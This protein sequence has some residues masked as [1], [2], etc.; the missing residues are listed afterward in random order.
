MN[1]I[2]SVVLYMYSTMAVLAEYLDA[3]EENDYETEAHL[4]DDKV[5]A[6]HRKNEAGHQNRH[7]AEEH[8]KA[9]I[10]PEVSAVAERVQQAGQ[11]EVS[12]H[13]KT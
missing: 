1:S 10:R 6:N 11:E 9:H 7:Q 4:S 5:A 3:D 2:L 12:H 13:P 8:L